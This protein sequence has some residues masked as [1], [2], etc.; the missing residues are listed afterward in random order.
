MPFIQC[1]SQKIIPEI[2]TKECNTAIK[3]TVAKKKKI[4]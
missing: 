3:F 2:I 4:K 1:D